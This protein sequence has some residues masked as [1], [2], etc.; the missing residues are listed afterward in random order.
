[1]GSIG[2]RLPKLLTAEQWL[3]IG[4]RRN[5]NKS[6]TMVHGSGQINIQPKLQL[7]HTSRA[8][9]GTCH[10]WSLLQKSPRKTGLNWGDSS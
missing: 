3:T 8:P 4:D 2:F 6:T 7:I 9:T 1:M 10:L 5:R